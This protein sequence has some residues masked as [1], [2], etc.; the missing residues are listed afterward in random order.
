MQKSAEKLLD[1]HF[2]SEKVKADTKSLS[3]RR[4][5]QLYSRNSGRHVRINPD[6]SVDAMGEDGD[7]YGKIHKRVYTL[8]FLILSVVLCL[9]ES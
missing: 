4:F 1:P 8:L 6:R 2:Q 9:L 3:F 7:K 5:T